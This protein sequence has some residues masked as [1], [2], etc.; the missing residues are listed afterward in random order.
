MIPTC[1]SGSD[2]APGVIPAAMAVT[3]STTGASLKPDSASSTPEICRGSGTRRSTENTAA[4]SVEASTAATRKAIC[5]SHPRN[6][7]A[8]TPTTSTDTPTPTVASTAAG[9]TDRRM[10]D[11]RVVIPPST[12]MRTS[13][14]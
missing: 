14:A 8:A 11:H 12:R 13:A 10:P 6:K 4:A 5:Q 2:V 3:R 9:A 1:H 7:C